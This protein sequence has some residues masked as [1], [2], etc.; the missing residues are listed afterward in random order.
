MKGKGSDHWIDKTSITVGIDDD[1]RIEG[2]K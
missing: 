1:Q 2:L